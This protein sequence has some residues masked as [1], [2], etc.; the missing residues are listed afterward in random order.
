[1][2]FY[3]ATTE[4]NIIKIL[5]E[6]IIKHSIG[7]VV[8]L[9]KDPIDACKFLA[10]RGCKKICVLELSLKENEVQ[11][12]FDHSEAFFKCKAFIH[13]GDIFLHGTEKIIEYSVDF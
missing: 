3:H 13:N 12:S 11:E 8:F 1:M 10:I 2:K 4:E 6:G 5:E 9:C 7:G